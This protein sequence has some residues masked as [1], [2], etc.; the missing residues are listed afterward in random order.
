[1]RPDRLSP[2]QLRVLAQHEPSSTAGIEEADALREARAEP[3]TDAFERDAPPQK[4]GDTVKAAPTPAE[5]LYEALQAGDVMQVHALL[6]EHP[7]LLNAQDVYGQTPLTR[8]A[9]ANDPALLGLLLHLGAAV[10]HPNRQGLSPAFAAANDGA[11]GALEVLLKRST[12]EQSH[13]PLWR[14]LELVAKCVER[15]RQDEAPNLDN[16]AATLTGAARKS[17]QSGWAL[18]KYATHLEAMKENPFGVQ[19]EGW[20]STAFHEQ[21]VRTFLEFAV[22]PKGTLGE[23]LVQQVGEEALT[24]ALVQEISV[25][26]EALRHCRRTFALGRMP[27]ASL[28]QELAT[29]EA[30]AVLERIENISG[31]YQYLMPTGW[32][33]HAIYLSAQRRVVE[34][35]EVITFRVDNNGAGRTHHNQPDDNRV[36]PLV[37][38]VPVA[39]MKDPEVR[40]AIVTAIRD[41]MLLKTAPKS[42]QNH[43]K[44]YEELGVLRGL[45][46]ATH[47]PVV[48]AEG[49]TTFPARYKQTAGNCVVENHLSGFRLRFGEELAE[50]LLQNEKESVFRR[51]FGHM[52]PTAFRAAVTANEDRVRRVLKLDETS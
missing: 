12:P 13:E 35:Q 48:L 8:A 17:F 52:T 2:L 50:R 11:T 39:A 44:F 31:T 16:W 30:Q 14:S 24:E 26:L 15:L 32:S 23:E 47:G 20:S 25:L 9:S 6:G 27:N 29:R 43:A 19:A 4:V 3:P 38:N 7:K 10:N 34:D 37:T 36:Y 33:T 18:Q 22:D 5:S 45:L 40:E 28:A 42:S 46:L 41:L 21:R 51:M 1:M 49:D